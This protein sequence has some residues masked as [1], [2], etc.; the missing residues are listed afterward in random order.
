VQSHIQATA[1]DLGAPGF[2][3]RYGHGLADAARALRCPPNTPC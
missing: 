2:D 1:R 3:H